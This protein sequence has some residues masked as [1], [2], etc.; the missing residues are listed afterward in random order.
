M[1]YCRSMAGYPW[2]LT[3]SAG[4]QPRPAILKITKNSHH[5][6]MTM[7][8]HISLEMHDL[9]LSQTNIHQHAAGTEDKLYEGIRT[10][11]QQ[12]N[13][14]VPRTVRYYINVHGAVQRRNE[15]PS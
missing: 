5:Q 9:S 13:A 3:S 11:R 12:Y 14:N 15:P 4:K 7:P 8:M 10:E 2:T 6:P 1:D